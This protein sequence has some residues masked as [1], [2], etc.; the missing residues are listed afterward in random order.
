MT[1]EVGEIFGSITR[2]CDNFA[3]LQQLTVALRLG[4]RA[5]ASDRAFMS[6]RLFF[7][8]NFGPSGAMDITLQ[9]TTNGTVTYAAVCTSSTEAGEPSLGA[10][11]PSAGG[12]PPCRCRT[13]SVQW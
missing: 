6:S 7:D 11:T 8:P 4:Y 13:A 10:T 1:G 3:V 9:Q 2:G 5:N 12:C